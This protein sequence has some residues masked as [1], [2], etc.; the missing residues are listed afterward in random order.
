MLDNRFKLAL[1]G[2]SLSFGLLSCGSVFGPVEQRKVVAYELTD[3]TISAVPTCPK[4]V[5]N[6]VIFISP[7]R[8]NV[9]YDSAKMYYAK[10]PFELNTFGYSQ[11][12][13]NPSD[14]LTQMITK[15]IVT[16]CSFGGIA[17]GNALANADY[18]L[19]TQL[20]TLRQDLTSANT[21]SVKLVIYVQLVNLEHNKVVAYK[22]FDEHSPSAVGPEAM[23]LATNKLVTQ[24]DTEMLEWLQQQTLATSN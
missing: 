24:F 5:R 9:P 2:L 23:V 6:D 19:V 22:I 13:A 17:T 21:A 12:V 15:K 20:V 1:A 7:M 11:W 3:V 10:S 14:M 8:A 4:T 16:S 18:R